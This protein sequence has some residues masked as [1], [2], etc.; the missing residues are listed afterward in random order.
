MTSDYQSYLRVY[1]PNGSWLVD[2]NNH[3]PMKFGEEFYKKY[4]GTLV[5]IPIGQTK[6][7]FFEYLLADEVK[8][9]NYH[10]TIQKQSGISEIQGEIEVINT[11]GTIE[12]HSVSSK[13]DWFLE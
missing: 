5:Q 6:T 4:F 7:Y 10:L 1:T 8:P 2:S 3:H 13:E 11:D 12:K 9:E